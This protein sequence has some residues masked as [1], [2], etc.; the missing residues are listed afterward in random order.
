MLFNLALKLT[1]A[2]YHTLGKFLVSHCR[3]SKRNVIFLRLHVCV[4]VGH[5][6]HYCAPHINSVVVHSGQITK[7]A[8]YKK[9]LISSRNGK[10][11]SGP[12]WFYTLVLTTCASL[13]MIS[14]WLS[15]DTTYP[16]KP[17]PLKRSRISSENSWQHVVT[18]RFV[19]CLGL[20]LLHW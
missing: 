5:S 19:S 16:Q 13:P 6:L 7:I 20:F 9:S 18:G 12:L 14:R 1:R 10:F 4:C 17:Q 3:I 11:S 2:V 15:A 8:T